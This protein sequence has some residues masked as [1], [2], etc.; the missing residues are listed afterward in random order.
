MAKRGVKHFSAVYVAAG[1][2]RRMTF[3]A[4]DLAEAQALA[5]EWKVGLEGEATPPSATDAPPSPEAYD[6][7]T[8]RRILGNISRSTIYCWL[9]TGD[10]ERVPGIAKVLLT[11]R[12]IDRL[13]SRASGQN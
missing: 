1:A 11:R 10:L 8:T 12:S 9:A 5:V 13:V 4:E 3:E 6:L 7:P 2:V